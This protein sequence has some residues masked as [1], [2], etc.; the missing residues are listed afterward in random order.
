MPLYTHTNPYQPNG[1][2]PIQYGTG[3]G[4]QG[5]TF[6]TNFQYQDNGYAPITTGVGTPPSPYTPGPTQD[7]LVLPPP[8]Y[9]VDTTQYGKQ[10]GPGNSF[11]NTLRY[12]Y[13]GC[14]PI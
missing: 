3:I 13:I 14:Y 4:V 12:I 6:M 11:Y 8:P 10:P 5:N 2:T 1:Y 9:T 7:G